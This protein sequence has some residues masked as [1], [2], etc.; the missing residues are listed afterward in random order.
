MIHRAQAAATQLGGSVDVRIGA[1]LSACGVGE[2]AD[3]PQDNRL[4]PFRLY[5]ANHYQFPEWQHPSDRTPRGYAVH[6]LEVLRALLP[7]G[8]ADCIAHPF[9]HDGLSRLFE[10]PRVVTSA[11][12]DAEL[13]DVLE[14]G[15]SNNVAWELS[16]PA[17][18]ADAPFARRLWRIGQETG[19]TFL[20]GTD[21]HRPS[22]IDPSPSLPAL[23]ACLSG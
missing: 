13:A 22:E 6:M 9:S 21:A 16:M 15:R 17:C 20:L 12:S 14:L 4:V 3:S 19:V 23:S 1:E 7:T 2:F 11:I 5:A 8:R 18:L 10:D